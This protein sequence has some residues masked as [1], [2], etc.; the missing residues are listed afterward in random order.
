MYW[1]DPMYFVFLAPALLL[2]FWAQ[3]RIRSTY[4]TA[5]QQPAPMSGAAAARKILD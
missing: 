2:A 1:F 5:S 4:A 3:A